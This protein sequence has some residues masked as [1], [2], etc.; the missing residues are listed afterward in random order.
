[1]GTS[2]NLTLGAPRRRVVVLTDSRE[3]RI[4]FAGA[5]RVRE[6]A[7][8]DTDPARLRVVRM[9]DSVGEDEDEGAR[10]LEV[11]EDFDAVW[12]MPMSPVQ[13]DG[14]QSSSAWAR[15][16]GRSREDQLLW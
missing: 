8:E 3:E 4:D 14:A 16:G 2:R 9:D 6:D 12:R 10:L 1:M 15:S 5:G 11:A 7:I 13:N